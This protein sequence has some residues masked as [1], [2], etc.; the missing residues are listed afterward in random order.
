MLT[1]TGYAESVAI[2]VGALALDMHLLVTVSQSGWTLGP[3]GGRNRRERQ[4][5]LRVYSE[6]HAATPRDDWG[7]NE[8]RAVP[9]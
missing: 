9:R 6:G 4:V 2:G 3:V 1:V 7:A 8:N 5:T